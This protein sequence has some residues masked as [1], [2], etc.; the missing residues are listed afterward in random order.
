[1]ITE[2]NLSQIKVPGKDHQEYLLEMGFFE[3]LKKGM[4]IVLWERGYSGCVR[5]RV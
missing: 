5:H 1:L 3:T 4:Y 2:N